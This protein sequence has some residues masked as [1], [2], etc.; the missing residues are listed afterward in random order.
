MLGAEI[1]AQKTVAI[2]APQIPF[3]LVQIM[4]T[5]SISSLAHE[6]II[7]YSRTVPTE[8][9]VR[10]RANALSASLAISA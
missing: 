7:T 3:P 9:N 4:I 1:D 5:K 2:E 8:H 6:Q 10:S